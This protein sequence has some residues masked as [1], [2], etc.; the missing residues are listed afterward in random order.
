MSRVYY[1]FDPELGADQGRHIGNGW[2]HLESRATPDGSH[3]AHVCWRPS[4]GERL[5]YLRP[6]WSGPVST[7]L[8]GPGPSRPPRRRD[9]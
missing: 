8:P 9:H 5:I 3:E 2:R 7:L 4:T 6:V 1:E